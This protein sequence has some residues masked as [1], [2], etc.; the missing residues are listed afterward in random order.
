[1]EHETRGFFTGPGLDGAPA[2]CVYLTAVQLVRIAGAQASLRPM[3]EALFHRIILLPAPANRTEPLRC[4]REIFRDPARLVDLSV[5]LYADRSHAASASMGS[6][7]LCGNVATTGASDD[8]AL[9]RLIIDAMEECAVALTAAAQSGATPAIS[10]EAALQSAVECVVALLGSLQTLC[11]GRLSS[12][13]M[14]DET[15][16]VIQQRYGQLREVDYRGPLT[17]QSMARLPAVYRYVFKK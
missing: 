9:F 2:R 15:V 11:T 14:D 5:I 3:L 8:M 17:Y 6:G 12:D 16:A 7:N 4:V 13:V 10:S 1:M